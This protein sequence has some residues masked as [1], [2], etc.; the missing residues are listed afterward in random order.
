[1]NRRPPRHGKPPQESWELLDVATLRQSVLMVSVL[2]EIDVRPCDDGVVLEATMAIGW[3][4]DL[5]VPWW[6]IGQTL[7]ASAV[8]PTGAAARARLST[9]LR[10]ARAIG[11]LPVGTLRDHLRPMGLPHDHAL[12][13]GSAWIHNSVEG[14]A[15]DL[16]F[17]L[18]GVEADPD[19]ITIAPPGLL[20]A[21]GLDLRA[22][23]PHAHRYLER[24]GAIAA[25]RQERDPQTP[26]RPMGDCDVLT[27]LGST[28]LRSALAS[29]RGVGMRAA[30]IPMRRRGWVDPSHLDAAFAL[31]AAAATDPSE[32]GFTR[33]VLIT[34]DGVWEAQEG[35]DLVEFALRDAVGAGLWVREMRFGSTG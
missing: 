15:L 18:A 24:M 6:R 8:D 28:V 29:D 5:L 9:W 30:A 19:A 4:N 20:E 33:P 17:G 14:G 2:D 13:P 11:D 23:W 27:L 7:G 21:T 35:I 16:G 10:L 3:S 26:L 1:M 32:R 31:G 25:I 22:M 12:H 34:V